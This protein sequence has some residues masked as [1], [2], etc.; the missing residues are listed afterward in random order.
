MEVQTGISIY[1]EFAE[2][3]A[4]LSPEKVMAYHPS[5]NQQE[6]F[7]FLVEIKRNKGLNK[8]QKVEFEHIMTMERIIRLA[9]VHAYKL[10]INEPVYS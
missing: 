8:V 7:D 6:R 4:S 1:Q 5:Q 3:L 10:Q 2:F 9:K